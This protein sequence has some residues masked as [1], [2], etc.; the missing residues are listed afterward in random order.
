MARTAAALIIGNEIL[1]GK[2]AEANLVELARMLRSLGIVLRRVMTVPD[3]IDV[4]AAD[5]RALSRD[6]DVVFTSGGVGPTHDDVTMAALAHAFGVPVVVDATFECLIREFYGDNASE[7]HLLMARVPEGSEVVFDDEVRWPITRFHNIWSI[8]GV[9]EIFKLKLKLIARK[10]GAD[11]PILSRAVFTKLEEANLKPL[12]DQVVAKFPDV[13]VGSY[14]TWSDPTYRTKVT[15]DSLDAE[16][17][18]EASASF[19]SSVPADQ[20]VRSE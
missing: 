12:I 9:P 16:R 13:E 14:P 2:I 19:A 17:I 8:P 1:S 3:E 15:F 10:L 11:R 7:G 4:I 20:F 5:V 18:A 6:H